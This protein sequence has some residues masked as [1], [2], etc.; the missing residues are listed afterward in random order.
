M[1]V[2]ATVTAAKRGGRREA[3]SFPQDR[4]NPD[5]KD[6][7]TRP[8]LV[9]PEGRKACPVPRHG[10]GSECDHIFHLSGISRIE[11]KVAGNHETPAQKTAGVTGWGL[12]G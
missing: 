6:G 1:T 4:G 2:A 12:R 10:V 3:P 9:M 8:H 11:R 7:N 5:A